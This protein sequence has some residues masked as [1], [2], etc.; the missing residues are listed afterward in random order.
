VRAL[1]AGEEQVD[2]LVHALASFLV[3]YTHA[4]AEEYDRF[5]FPIEPT[6]ANSGWDGTQM[7]F[8]SGVAQI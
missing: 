1:T 6:L 8:Y 7:E 4:D 2:P 3:A 5:R